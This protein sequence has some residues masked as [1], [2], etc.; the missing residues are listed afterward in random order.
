V[1]ES[2]GGMHKTTM[3]AQNRKSLLS[4]SGGFNLFVLE[5]N[6]S[7][8]GNLKFLNFNNMKF[9]KVHSQDQM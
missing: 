7:L 8:P 9:C 1:N 5:T 3:K 2:H 6:E 4:I